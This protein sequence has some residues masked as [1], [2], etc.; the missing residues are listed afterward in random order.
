MGFLEEVLGF[1]A[2]FLVRW[3]DRWVERFTSGAFVGVSW[4]DL[5]CGGFS[6][7]WEVGCFAVCSAG[8]SEC[9]G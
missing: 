4:L 1:G 6:L 9:R 7:E 2:S 8:L 5:G 3:A